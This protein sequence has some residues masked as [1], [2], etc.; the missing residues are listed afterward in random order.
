MTSGQICATPT[1]SSAS[2]IY[3]TGH[4][5][6]QGTEYAPQKL[7]GNWNGQFVRVWFHSAILLLQSHTHFVKFERVLAGDFSGSR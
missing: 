4:V 7:A 5:G 6:E 2:R 1:T 3:R